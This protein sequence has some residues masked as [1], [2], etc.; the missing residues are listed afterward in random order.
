MGANIVVAEFEPANAERTAAKVRA[1][2]R[3]ALVV[4]TDVV[5]FANVRWWPG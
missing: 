1:L 2:D 4:P 3:R 5:D